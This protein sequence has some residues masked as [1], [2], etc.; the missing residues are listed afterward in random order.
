MQATGMEDLPDDCV[1]LIF[2]QLPPFVVLQLRQVCKT[3]KRTVEEVIAALD[4]SSLSLSVDRFVKLVSVLRNLQHLRVAVDSGIEWR[5]NFLTDAHIRALR[6]VCPALKSLLAPNSAQLTSNGVDVIATF[7]S[8]TTLEISRCEPFSRG[9]SE[10]LRNCSTLTSLDLAYYQGNVFRVRCGPNLRHLGIREVQNFVTLGFDEMAKATAL[11][12][13]DLRGTTWETAAM[14]AQLQEHTSFEVVDWRGN[15]DMNEQMVIEM[16]R[17]S[18]RLR[19][20]YLSGPYLATLPRELNSKTN[21]NL[22][23]VW[24]SGSY[25]LDVQAINDFFDQCDTLTALHIRSCTSFNSASLAHLMGRRNLRILDLNHNHMIYDSH[26]SSLVSTVHLEELHLSCVHTSGEP[27]LFEA[28]A[29]SSPRLRSLDLSGSDYI[30]QAGW[31]IPHLTSWK[32]LAFLDVTLKPLHCAHLIDILR[33]APKLQTLRVTLQPN[34]IVERRAGGQ[35]AALK[36]G[37]YLHPPTAKTIVVDTTTDGDTDIDEELQK[38]AP[39]LLHKFLTNLQVTNCED[40]VF[41]WLLES[42][43]YLNI[44]EW[45]QHERGTA[46]FN[47]TVT[48]FGVKL[49]ERGKSLREVALHEDPHL[50]DED[51]KALVALRGTL[52]AVFVLECVQV[53]MLAV[54]SLTRNGI[55]AA[56]R[57][58]PRTAQQKS[59]CALL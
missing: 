52:I 58:Q 14:M 46:A 45:T 3:W 18:P 54:E 16:V 19:E 50:T 15:P 48:E 51:V 56:K 23:R 2:N 44:V 10:L 33:N 41:L 38:P 24:L 55:A 37:H 59:G 57:P 17:R 6:K 34:G 28:L 12:S 39:Q 29:E 5:P 31:L 7:P 25:S 42:C 36:K 27:R 40:A 49:A 4:L 26:L 35:M 13:L 11:T 20:L 47:R 22:Q 30:Q 8:L 53:T 43:P 1:G 21:P 32:D 9:L